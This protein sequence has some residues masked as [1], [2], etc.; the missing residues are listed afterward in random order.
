[1]RRSP[2]YRATGRG[3]QTVALP[4]PMTAERSNRVLT[5][6]RGN[7][8]NEWSVRK[9]ANIM[10][11]LLTREAVIPKIERLQY[12]YSSQFTIT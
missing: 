8:K 4:L 6:E 1:M 9:S 5:P 10:P 11:P 7:H 3:M 2:P 12:E